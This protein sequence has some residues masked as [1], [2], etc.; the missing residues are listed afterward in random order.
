MG[1]RFSS[2]FLR[3]AFTRLRTFF[4]VLTV[5]LRQ[6]TFGQRLDLFSSPSPSL[7][8]HAAEEM[9]HFLLRVLELLHVLPGVVVLAVNPIR[10]KSPLVVRFS[11]EF[12]HYRSKGIASFSNQ[13][14]LRSAKK[15][16]YRSMLRWQD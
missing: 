16:A 2:F 4:A 10:V 14:F 6:T 11:E 1:Y 7:G 3:A 9:E 15:Y 5:P 8:L 12:R 13:A